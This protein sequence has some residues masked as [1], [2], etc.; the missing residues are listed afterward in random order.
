MSRLFT[1]RR[2]TVVV[3]LGQR[4]IRVAA[5]EFAGEAV[6]FHGITAI[7][8]GASGF[9]SEPA[10]ERTL[11][12]R[13][14][15]IVERKGWKGMRATCLLPRSAA[16]V[17]SFVLPPMP[18][19]D[20][21]AAIE[22]KLRQALHFDVDEATFGFRRV[23][24]I[25]RDGHRQTLILVGA[26]RAA[27]VARVLRVV[28]GAGLE[29]V[30]VGSAA[31]SLANLAYHARL[32][33]EGETTVHVDI[34]GDS[35]ILNLLHGR[36]LRFS[37]EVDIGGDAFTHALMR[38]IITAEGA[39]QLEY[40]QAE[41]VKKSGGYPREDEDVPLPHGVRSSDVLPLL[42]PVLQRLTMEVARSCDYLRELVGG[43]DVDRIVLT[44]TA[45]R[46][47]NLDAA[48]AENLGLPV[49]RMD[50][51]ARATAH[52]HLSIRDRGD[53]DPAGFA[54]LLGY[55]VGQQQPVNLIPRE[56]WTERFA[57]RV[58]RV[59]RTFAPAAIAAALCVFLAA[60][61]IQRTY[62]GAERSLCEA[63]EQLR[64]RMERHA[65]TAAKTA[66]R[67]ARAARA[68]AA[69]GRVLPWVGVM[70]E[71]AAALP[72]SV[73]MTALSMFSVAGE[74][75]AIEFDAEAEED[76]VP[77]EVVVTELTVAM[78][79]S[80]FFDDVRV[81]E[82]SFDRA[83]RVGHLR[84]ALRVAAPRCRAGGTAP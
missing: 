30:A 28:R 36:M 15:D 61:P 35:T 81:V 70:K 57:D 33:A 18:D 41:D 8:A 3:E 68:T 24:E 76:R 64:A 45:S 52:W 72:T 84:V 13:L 23:R 63:S 4:T 25:D 50:P 31:E 79:E 32:S 39:R 66:D 42:E 69:R 71:L 29:P 5:A 75:P 1:K 49:V 80:A 9:D 65:A 48:L 54:M 6:R 74:L 60:V 14:G 37:R 40:E 7:A 47:R 62:D 38:P 43:G 77:F 16:S 53:T 44:G 26:A 78:G 51:V 19:E 82:A 27:D 22:I 21:E 46:M 11:A 17:L 73:R 55:S 67:L 58:R 10:D 56:Y 20:V 59:R 34:G 12:R 2:Q 83:N